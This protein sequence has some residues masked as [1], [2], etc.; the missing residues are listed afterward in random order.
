[1][2]P[3]LAGGA[4]AISHPA[5]SAV[6]RLAMK[7]A[8]PSGNVILSAVIA[9]PWVLRLMIA[10]RRVRDSVFRTVAVARAALEESRGGPINYGEAEAQRSPDRWT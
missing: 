6:P 1:M 2:Q 9:S 4:A 7:E 10:P 3:A 5:I 8:L